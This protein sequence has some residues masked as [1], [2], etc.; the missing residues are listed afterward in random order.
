MSSWS[1][2]PAGPLL[3][4]AI[5]QSLFEVY[6]FVIGYT[7]A[8]H[9]VC[10]Q[11]RLLTHPAGAALRLPIHITGETGTGK[12]LIASAVHR[13]NPIQGGR[14]ISVNIAAFPRDLAASALFGHRRGAYTGAQEDR[15]G[16]I[17]LAEGG[18]LFLDEVGD[19]PPDIQV[20][21]LRFLD[22]GEVRPIGSDDAYKVQTQLATATNA[23][24]AKLV[25]DGRFRLDLYHRLCGMTISL[26]PLRERRDDIPLL[27][28][29]FLRERGASPAIAD[30]T[31]QLLRERDWPGN[32]RQLKMFL[33]QLVLVSQCADATEAAHWLHSDIPPPS[34][35]GGES[36]TLGE[37]RRDFDRQVLAQRLR[38][39]AGDTQAVAQ[40]LGISR[41]SVYNLA[42]QL[43]VRIQDAASN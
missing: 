14:L 43:G 42:R 32:I 9:R 3:D 39:F 36:R 13:L 37:L 31:E 30:G 2:I 40:S 6:G 28:K 22:S 41:R 18:V 15:A 5:Q 11:I 25:E 8:M 27:V 38:R 16:A 34:P 23:D 26:P 7:E 12:D 19:A 20:M 10:R 17:K 29:T 33:D 4:V 35:G 21:L 24:L 1:D